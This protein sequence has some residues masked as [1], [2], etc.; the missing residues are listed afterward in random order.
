M[1]QWLL[2]RIGYVPALED[3]D[4]NTVSVSV[5]VLDE[6]ELRIEKD[7]VKANLEYAAIQ[8][9]SEVFAHLLPDRE[10]NTPPQTWEDMLATALRVLYSDNLSWEGDRDEPERRPIFDLEAVLLPLAA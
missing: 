5:E 4:D 6:T 10:I 8:L 2:N 3:T 9:R 1:W 7:R